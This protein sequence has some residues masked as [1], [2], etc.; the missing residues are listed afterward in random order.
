M[1]MAGARET[2]DEFCLS[3]DCGL[4][5]LVEQTERR[6][7]GFALARTNNNRLQAAKLLGI[8]RALLYKK[9]HAYGIA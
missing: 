1:I 9:L 8:S 5:E 3:E 2:N 7:L 4:A 6:A